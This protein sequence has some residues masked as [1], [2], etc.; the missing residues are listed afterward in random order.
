MKHL[1][2]TMKISPSPCQFF[3]IFSSAPCFPMNSTLRSMQKTN[4]KISVF[5]KKKNNIF[6]MVLFED[7]DNRFVS[8][9]RYAY[10]SAVWWLPVA[11]SFQMHLWIHCFRLTVNR[12]KPGDLEKNME[13]VTDVTTEPHCPTISVFINIKWGTW[14]PFTLIIIP[15]LY[16][17]ALM[18]A[19]IGLAC[20][21]FKH[22]LHFCRGWPGP[23]I[24]RIC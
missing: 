12:K 7:W 21:Y 3:Q 19:S 22:L 9:W 1:I 6:R 4:L 17:Q 15:Y 18:Q 5:L 8:R 10:L 20:T 16:S 24:Q 11:E 13:G 2:R 14:L 23:G